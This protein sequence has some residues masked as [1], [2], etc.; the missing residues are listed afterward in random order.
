MTKTD[1]RHDRPPVLIIDLIKE[2][3]KTNTKQYRPSVV[4]IIVLLVGE[5]KK[6]KKR[7]TI[8]TY[9]YFTC[10]RDKIKYTFKGGATLLPSVLIDTPLPSPTTVNRFPFF[11]S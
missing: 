3:T 8:S 6:Y 7:P 11:Y 2:M 9:H 10:R 5:T 1:T 4:F